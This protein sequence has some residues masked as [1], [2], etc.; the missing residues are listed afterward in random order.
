MGLL[1]EGTP[2]KW[3]D[4]K[5]YRDHVRKHGI[6]QFLSLWRKYEHKKGSILWWGDEVEY[7]MV[8]LCPIDKWARL[9]LRAPEILAK[10]KH[11]REALPDC[12]CAK[13]ITWHP[14][15]ANWML[16]ATPGQPYEDKVIDLLEVEKNMILRRQCIQKFLLHGEHLITLPVFPRI[17]CPGFTHPQ[18]K[19]SPSGEVSRS[20]YIP[21]EAINPHPRFPTLTANIRKRRGEKVSIGM[22]IYQDTD[23]AQTLKA[24]RQGVED[25]IDVAEISKLP[26]DGIYMDCMAFGMGAGCLQMTFQAKDVTEARFLYDQLAIFAPIMLA[27]TA[28]TP[29]W[30]GMLA[31]TDVRWDVIVGAVDDRTD[32]ERGAELKAG[33]KF[34]PKSRYSSIDCYIST[35]PLMQDAYND[36]EVVI[37]DEARARL[38]AADEAA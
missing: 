28:A 10:L 8:K 38:L 14:E 29:I 7:F 17:G 35:S 19:P 5:Q 27:L 31:D 4:A 1:T 30:K 33:E 13:A 20:L 32:G 36:V 34:I 2:L 21:D 6:E 15:Y 22:P 37:N 16:E 26:L 3:E 12:D 25:K 24:Q 23:T 9:T 11:F 18:M